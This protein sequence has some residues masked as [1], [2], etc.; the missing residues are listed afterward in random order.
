M[1]QVEFIAKTIRL[2]V[3]QVE[4]KLTEMILD[5]K[6]KAT[7]DKGSVLI[8]FDETPADRTYDL[9]IETIHSMAK[10]VDALYLKAKKL[11]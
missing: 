2:P 4:H 11:S 3:Q 9:A 6:L 7:L 8:V 5:D 1:F 10:V